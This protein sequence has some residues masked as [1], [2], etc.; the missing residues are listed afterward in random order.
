MLSATLR[1]SCVCRGGLDFGCPLVGVRA[2]SL[3]A[4]PRQSITPTGKLSQEIALMSKSFSLDEPIVN[5]AA[6]A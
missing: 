2:R 3:L 4:G 1:F 5:A 6:R